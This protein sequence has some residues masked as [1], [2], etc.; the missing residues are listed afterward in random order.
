MNVFL[1][2]TIRSL[3]KNR[4]RTLVTIIGIVLSVALVT[5]VLEG[6]Y[7]GIL[8]MIRYREENSGTMHGLFP[9]LSEEGVK[10]LQE[11]QSVKEV[12]TMR[13]TGFAL[14]YDEPDFSKPYLC[15]ASTDQS[16]AKMTGISVE[17][18]RFPESPDELLVPGYLTHRRPDPVTVGSQVTLSVGKTRTDGEVM[19]LN[20]F[21]AYGD[22]VGL[23]DGE[24]CVYTVV[25]T[26]WYCN[27]IL[28]PNISA[29]GLAITAGEKEG[30]LLAAVSVKN[31]RQFYEWADH[32]TVSQN[33]LD[34]TLLLTCYGVTRDSRVN[35]T[36][37]MLVSLLLLLVVFGSILLVYNSFSISVSERTRQFGILRSIGATKKQ[38]R[39]AVFSEA[40]LLSLIG[41]PLGLLVGFAG[42]A[43]VLWYLKDIVAMMYTGTA[44]VNASLRF[45]FSFLAL[46]VS[47]SIGLFT[48]LAS[49]WIPAI[50]A[51]RVRPIEAVRQTKDIRLRA[52]EIRTP[53][54]V[55]KIFG[56]EGVLASKNYKRN[57]KQHRAVVWSLALSIL[58]FVSAF[59]FIRYMSRY[60]DD[61]TSN[62]PKV[63]L[64]KNIELS[65]MEDPEELLERLDNAAHV[66][67]SA[68]GVTASGSVMVNLFFPEEAAPDPPKGTSYTDV[69]S[70]PNI[71]NTFYG[72]TAPEG[73]SPIYLAGDGAVLSPI[74][75]AF[76]DDRTFRNLLKDNGISEEAYF[77]SASPQGVLYNSGMGQYQKSGKDY[78]E[79][80]YVP[81]QLIQKDQ[82]PLDAYLIRSVS[83]DGYLEIGAVD[84]E[85]LYYPVKDAAGLVSLDPS[86]LDPEKVIRI[87]AEESTVR[88][89]LKIGG[90]IQKNAF[91]FADSLP[92]LYYPYSMLDHVV[93]EEIRALT[94]G[95]GS[96]LY[97]FNTD[98]R[99]ESK[100][101]MNEILTEEALPRGFNEVSGYD[102]G[103][104]KL[105]GVF[106]YGFILLISLI[107]VA[108]AFN[109]AHTNVMLR[110]RE[111]AI[112]RSIGLSKKGF[113]KMI[114]Y[115]WFRESTTGFIIGLL[116]ATAFAFAIW[117]VISRMIQRAFYLPWES[118]LIS[119]GAT[120][121]VMA[122][123]VL[124]AVRRVRTNHP[125]EVLKDENA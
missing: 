120:L 124:Y 69:S 5:S 70:L 105:I 76:L 53:R 114:V 116:I 37:T 118:V 59:S 1:T 8:Y 84:G 121:V 80:V 54:I 63:D 40:F 91:F 60:I 9:S 48:T 6:A 100:A 56:I 52:K 71:H 24:E 74:N 50:R 122:F 62:Q 87:K 28:M 2:Y 4:A 72:E 109:T 107:A 64:T 125:V 86:L 99:M 47:V 33:W 15:I 36:V 12:S 44:P 27:D 45:E 103:I 58:L 119:A 32:Q 110:R 90:I 39:G 117:K 46:L 41:I 14:V 113:F 10:A 38:I 112:L 89:D 115:E 29:C 77:D 11:D 94:G 85:R 101:A 68:F 26:Y 49:A 16:F 67:K 17:S 61:M 82:I 81:Y 18:G 97:F 57:R 51:N 22:N 95:F 75:F 92:C 108:N 23:S 30:D 106:S 65:A 79:M 98:D 88:I 7:S 13:I 42:I 21:H 93:S 111:F 25:G 66:T 83:P 55:G 20:R 96:A 19:S 102:R 73:A 43:A 34:N 123:S 35:W 104:I 31:P 3:K 78:D